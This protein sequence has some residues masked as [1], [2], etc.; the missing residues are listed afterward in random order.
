MKGTRFLRAALSGAKA[1]VPGEQMKG[2]RIKL[3][4]NESP[5][6]PTPRAILAA[7]NSAGNLMR[8]PKPG[9]DDAATAA[10]DVW[11]VDPGN[12]LVGNGSDEILR[13]VFQAYVDPGDEVLWSSPT[14][15]LY[16]VLAAFA[17]ARIVDIPRDGEFRLRTADVMARA[18][19]LTI[20]ASPNSP[21][22]TV[23]PL[24]D[25]EKIA[26]TGRLLLIDEAYADFAGATAMGL[27][28]RYDNII[29]ARTLSKSYALAGLR[30]GFA[31]A[32]PPLIAELHTFRDAY[33]VGMLANAGAAAALK[34]Q[35]YALDLRGRILATRSRLE[36]GLR[37]LGWKVYPTGANFVFAEPPGGDAGTVYEFLRDRGILVRWFPNDFRIA[38]GV[39]ITVGTDA[40]IEELLRALEERK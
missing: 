14:Y 35:E 5:Y 2:I 17:G 37:N 25:I 11:G 32:A 4:T 16:D 31:V 9:A 34:D 8:Y 19:K 3:N 22:G 40:E 26:A 29:V 12:V 6:P 28:R 24:A 38:A 27:I 23:T 21:T 10:A 18:A 39:R 33:N 15:T 7:A 1:Y 13:L 36:S 30:T 20:I